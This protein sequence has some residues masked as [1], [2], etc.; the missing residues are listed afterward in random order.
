MTEGNCFC[1]WLQP[2]LSIDAESLSL[3]TLRRLEAVVLSPVGEME[4]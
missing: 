3:F 1:I 2:G 4:N